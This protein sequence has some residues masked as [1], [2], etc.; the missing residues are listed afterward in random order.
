M[1]HGRCAVYYIYVKKKKSVFIA[2]CPTCLWIKMA[3]SRS[4]GHVWYY[5][6]KEIPN[7]EKEVC[8]MCD[9]KKSL[10]TI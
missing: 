6:R 8:D 9:Y 3:S 7:K 5:F 1:L 4:P 10:G 2:Q